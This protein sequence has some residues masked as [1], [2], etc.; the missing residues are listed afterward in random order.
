MTG[1]KPCLATFPPVKTQPPAFCFKE[2]TDA[3]FQI[4]RDIISCTHVA[5]AEVAQH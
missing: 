1:H 3:L 5:G 2:T 4:L